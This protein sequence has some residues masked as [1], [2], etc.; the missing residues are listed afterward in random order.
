MVTG[1][2]F[3][4]EKKNLA[5]SD[6]YTKQSNNLRSVASKGV[7]GYQIKRRSADLHPPIINGNYPFVPQ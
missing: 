1:Y 4:R 7:D 5:V 3:H 6:R 2:R